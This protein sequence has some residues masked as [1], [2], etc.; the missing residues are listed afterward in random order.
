MN[1][2]DFGGKAYAKTYA[3]IYPELITKRTFNHLISILDGVAVAPDT[4][5]ARMIS[6]VLTKIYNLPVA[7]VKSSKKGVT[8]QYKKLPQQVVEQ[9]NPYYTAERTAIRLDSSDPRH[10][11]L[12]YNWSTYGKNSLPTQGFYDTFVHVRC[13][14][15]VLAVFQEYLKPYRADIERAK[16]HLTSNTPI[17]YQFGE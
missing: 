10:S 17:N 4:G 3:V 7:R 15:E 16:R 13:Y 2:V 8:I 6:D 9:I 1:A 5:D 12:G 14:D 11:Y